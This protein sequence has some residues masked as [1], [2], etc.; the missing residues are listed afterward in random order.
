VDDFTIVADDQTDKSSAQAAETPRRSRVGVIVAGMH[1]S[2]TSA[3]TRVIN[4]LGADITADLMPA[5]RDNERGFWESNRI[6]AIH[7]R[8]LEALGSRWDDPMPLPD[9]W[10]ETDAAQQAGREI[11]EE[12]DAQFADSSSFVVKDPRIA[13][14]L[15]LWLEL[16]DTLGIDPVVIIPFRDPFEV[17]QSLKH[18]DRLPVA[19]SGLLYAR[20]NLE[21][22]RAS[23]GRRRIFV[24]YQELLADRQ[25]V[26]KKIVELVWPRMTAPAGEALTEISSFVT[27]DLRHHRSTREDLANTPDIASAIIA[28]YDSMAEA[29][30][31][32]QETRL[33]ASF[34]R[35]AEMVTQA[36]KL[37]QGIVL[38][39]RESA[40]ELSGDLAAAKSQSA[41]LRAAF[42]AR[43]A[44]LDAALAGQASL[45]ERLKDE[46]AASEQRS[47]ELTATATARSTELARSRDELSTAQASLAELDGALAAQS[48]ETARLHGEV[49]KSRSQAEQ[50]DATSAALSAALDTI[51]ESTSWRVTSPLRWVTARL[52]R[53]S[54]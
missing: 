28:T 36:T 3:M 6:T 53:R 19:Q 18:R 32:G 23:R 43:S 2:G 14:F 48:A 16:F 35:I 41:E 1:R 45:I 17:A 11:A 20:C 7:D 22:E 21:A 33:C 51:R 31:T 52:P 46:L 47:A 10:S 37:F 44:E 25:R 40:R 39:Q 15:P 42:E 8:L 5:S 12:I 30:E 27:S 49:A 13:R 29:A 9:R 50:S 34:D 54:R 26:A 4:L 38:A 24:P